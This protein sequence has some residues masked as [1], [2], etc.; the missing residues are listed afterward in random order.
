MT[1]PPYLF[2]I[3]FE[4]LQFSTTDGADSVWSDEI[5]QLPQEFEWESG[6]WIGAKA[7]FIQDPAA[8]AQLSPA[9]NAA[10]KPHDAY[11]KYDTFNTYFGKFLTIFNPA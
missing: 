5:R 1:Q 11:L 10:K 7:A 3:D 6:I 4:L 8:T 2:D 9:I